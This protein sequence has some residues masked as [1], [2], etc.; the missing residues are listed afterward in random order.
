MIERKPLPSINRLNELLSYDP[1]TGIFRWKIDRRGG[2]RAGAIAGSKTVHGVHRLNLDGV[3]YYAHRIA[4]KMMTGQSVPDQI[5]HKNCN[6][7]YN[8]WEN[9]RAAKSDQNS[10][11]RSLGKANTSGAKGVVWHKQAK[12][13]QAQ[14]GAGKASRY[15]GLFSDFDEAAQAAEVARRDLHGEFARSV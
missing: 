3:S 1:A 5:D 10:M 13:W 8:V 11:N 12:K 9:L 15:I 2:A 7:A 6:P 4:W 14:V